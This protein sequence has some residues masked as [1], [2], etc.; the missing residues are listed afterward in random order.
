MK[1]QDISKT[2]RLSYQTY[3]VGLIMLLESQETSLLLKPLQSMCVK[4]MI[5]HLIKNQI[6]P[7]CRSLTTVCD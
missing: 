5:N 3:K 1:A 2:L 6:I 4:F 7:Y